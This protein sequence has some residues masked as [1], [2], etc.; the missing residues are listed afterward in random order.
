[1]NSVIIFTYRK[2]YDEMR[3]SQSP[4][5]GSSS[6]GNTQNPY[7]DGFNPFGQGGHQ[8][9]GQGNKYRKTYYYKTSNPEEAKKAFEEFFKNTRSPFG[10]G[11]QFKGFDDFM[12]GFQESMNKQWEQQRYVCI[13]KICLGNIKISIS[14]TSTKT[15]NTTNTK[16][17]ISIRT[18]NR[19]K[20]EVKETQE[21][22]SSVS[23]G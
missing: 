23:F 6:Y 10:K 15:T 17:I 13:N 8:Q 20:V 11:A 4:F 16:T 14:K 19:T 2:Q 5:G 9:S 12:K 18:T 7:G 3:E 1:M 21:M 22:N